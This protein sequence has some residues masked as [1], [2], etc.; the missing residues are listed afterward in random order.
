MNNKVVSAVALLVIG[1]VLF[2]LYLRAQVPSVNVG[3]PFAGTPAEQ[4]Q[5]GDDGI[6]VP[7]ADPVYEQVR[8][9]LVAS[10][11]DPVMISEHKPDR[12]LAML[13]PDVRDQVARDL[14]GWTTRL[15]TGTKLIGLKVSGK[16]TLGQK[17]GYPAV[18][19]DYVFAYA[20]EPP[21]PGKLRNQMEMVAASRQ[22]VTFTVTPAGLWPSDAAGFQYS[23]AC[24]AARDGFLA[25]QFTE[26]AAQ[27]DGLT[28]DD[29]RYFS[30][31]GSVPTEN[32]CD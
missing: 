9:A 3:I 31:D 14:P 27:S 12:F 15:K 29:R 16:M 4:W 7:G 1:A 8:Q 28:K 20:F 30:T 2:G 18:V 17:N 5:D 26:A 13:A 22:Q 21:D 23:I 6:G 24:R 10:R 11:T 32:T 25:P 19:T